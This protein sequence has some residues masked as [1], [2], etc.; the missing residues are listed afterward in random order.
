MPKKELA[1][2]G[3]GGVGVGNNGVDS[4]G[5]RSPSVP[6]CSTGRADC[7]TRQPLYTPDGKV[8]G[9][10][11][12]GV[13]TKTISKAHYL[14]NPPA[15]ALDAGAV[16]QADAAHVTQIVITDRDSGKVYGASLSELYTHGW[17][18]NRG[19]G[20]QYAMRLSRWH[21]DGGPA[22]APVVAP[23]QQPATAP[24]QLSLFGAGL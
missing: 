22:A 3:L 8:A 17:R 7:Q 9:V 20:E 12:G 23:A 24:G 1:H 16:A 4:G 10:I 2:S 15:I 19:W 18:F 13:L 14:T 21:V 6:D 11:V 5:R